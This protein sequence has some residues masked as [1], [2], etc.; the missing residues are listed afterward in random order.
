M[1]IPNALMLL[2]CTY[3]HASASIE[4]SITN[5]LYLTTVCASQ[6]SA[7]FPIRRMLW[8]DE[9]ANSAMIDIL[10]ACTWQE[11]KR[12][13]W[14]NVLAASTRCTLANILLHAH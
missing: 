5:P 1:T 4:L 2:E 11:R 13:R 14:A 7:F 8:Q 3:H 12:L 9:T 10:P 6:V